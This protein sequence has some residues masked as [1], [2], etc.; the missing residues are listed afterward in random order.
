MGITE[1]IEHCQPGLLAQ[2]MSAIR[3]Q[4]LNERTEQRHLH[5]ISRYVLFHS[6]PNPTETSL[7]HVASFLSYLAS[8]AHLSKARFKQAK[9]ALVFFY[10]DVLKRPV[11][12]THA[13]EVAA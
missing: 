13:I 4:E 12:F 8:H 5:W 11:D 10:Q 6:L 1:A 2:V 9:E 3:A 7:S